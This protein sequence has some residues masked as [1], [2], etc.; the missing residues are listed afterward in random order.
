MDTT[1]NAMIT[2]PQFYKDLVRLLHSS[3]NQLGHISVICD[4]SVKINHR[5]TKITDFSNFALL[6]ICINTTQY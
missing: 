2:L 4:W 5:I 3:N 1:Q 6:T